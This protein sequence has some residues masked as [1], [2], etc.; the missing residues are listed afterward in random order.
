MSDDRF[1]LPGALASD[2]KLKQLRPRLR[3]KIGY[4][5]ADLEAKGWKPKIHNAHRTQAQQDEKFR[6]GVSKS[7]KVKHHNWGLACDIIDRRYA[8][9]QPDD[10]P[11]IWEKAAQFFLDLRAS[12]DR[13]DLMIA[14][15]GWWFGGRRAGGKKPT[16]ENPT[17]RSVWNKWGLGW[18]PAHCYDHKATTEEQVTYGP[19]QWGSTDSD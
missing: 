13:A 3:L 9:P 2:P 7:R 16:A 11:E 10:P 6:R 5:L 4:V 14:N 15:G 18:D 12:C 1:S 19:D 8:W 17:H